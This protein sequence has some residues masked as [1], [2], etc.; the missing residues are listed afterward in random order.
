MR[1]AIERA[2][3]L[4]HS[5]VMLVGDAP[6]YARFGFAAAPT[7]RLRLPGPYESA[8]FLARELEPGALSGAAGLVKATGLFVPEP[9]PATAAALRAAA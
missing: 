8:R 1:S 4:G 5:S 6:Y 9:I 2:A 3:D 7:G